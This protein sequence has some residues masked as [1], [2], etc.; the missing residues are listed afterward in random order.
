[1]V[2]TMNQNLYS[3]LNLLGQNPV[4]AGALYFSILAVGLL[5]CIRIAVWV[6]W[7]SPFFSWGPKAFTHFFKTKGCL[8]LK[9]VGL[10]LGLSFLGAL[11]LNVS[12]FIIGVLLG[13]VVAFGFKYKSKAE[14]EERIK[15]QL[16][17]FM[18]ET[19]M[20]NPIFAKNTLQ[21]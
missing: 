1:M 16:P 18:R 15:N 12:G 17:L 6:Q 21:L 13:T 3:T 14:E 8:D 10:V 7:Q 19:E 20:P 9:S 2:P 11:W 4:Y 5:L